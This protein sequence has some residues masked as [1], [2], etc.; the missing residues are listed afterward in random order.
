MHSAKLCKNKIDDALNTLSLRINF[1]HRENQ[2]KNI[3]RTYVFLLD[4]DTKY[5]AE[6]LKPGIY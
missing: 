5:D 4:L 3:D 2:K 1:H 6:T